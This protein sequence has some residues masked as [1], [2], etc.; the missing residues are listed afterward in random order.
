MAF[1]NQDIIAAYNQRGDASE[2]DFVAYA[3]GQGVTA[4]QLLSAR[5]EMMA[6]APAPDAGAYGQW[7]G[8]QYQAMRDWSTGKSLD[9]VT[10]KAAE[11]GATADELGFAFGQYGGSGSQVS[12]TTGYG[13]VGGVGPTLAD[14]SAAKDW[15]FD[16]N[17]GWTQAKRKPPVPTASMPSTG[18]NLSN[19]QGTTN[20]NVTPD[21]TVANQLSQIIAADSPLMQQARTRAMQTANERGMLNT[22]MAGTAGEAA[23][24]DAAMPI[25]TAD[26]ATYGN[27]ARFNADA[28]NLFSRDNNAFT[29][30]AFMADFNLAANEWAKQQDQG[31]LYDQLD[32]SQKLTL[33]RD[34]VQNGYTGARDAILNGYQIARDDKT[35]AFTLQ[36]DATQN[37]F[38]AN[39]AELER[40][41]AMA[42]VAAGYSPSV[43]NTAINFANNQTSGARNTIT[44]AQQQFTSNVLNLKTSNLSAEKAEA[45]YIDLAKNYNQLISA[46]A[47]TAGW[48]A[49]SWQVVLPVKAVAAAPEQPAIPAGVTANNPNL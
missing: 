1:T 36:R 17:T 43:D 9:Q 42:R 28:S 29:R 10:A 26:A 40:Q 16:P 45:A 3:Q 37:E 32:Y 15:S 6:P 33:E 34:A 27:A 41:A 44:A 12:A 48:D 8:D 31:R 30:D 39:Q 14:G 22:S 23:L 13:T 21:Q 35:N 49:A 11:V 47:S 7:S 2:A 5:S 24:Y 20:W 38:S 4:D 25:A 18:I 46:T 19:L